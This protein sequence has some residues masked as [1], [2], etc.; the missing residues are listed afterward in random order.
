MSAEYPQATHK[1][2]LNVAGFEIPC[3]VLEDG[4]RVLYQRSLIPALGMSRGASS[5]GKGDRLAIF[6]QG[7][8]LSAFVSDRLREVTSTPF[9]FITDKGSLAYGYEATTLVDIC[10][11]VIEARNA[12]VLQKQQSHIAARCEILMRAFAKV[13]IIALVDEATGYQYVRDRLALEAILDKYLGKELAI[14]EKTFP[15]EFYKH[16]FE[17]RGWHYDPKSSKRPVL[18][19]KL[20]LDIVYRRLAPGLL[21]ELQTRA[22][23]NDKGQ[24]DH[25]LFL[26]L[27]QD[28]GYLRLKEHLS[29]LIVLMKASSSWASFYRLLQRALP[30]YG[31]TLE[32]PFDIDGGIDEDIN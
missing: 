14:W 21:K 25:K 26:L 12:G 31:D 3:Y 17:L 15:D 23:R 27:S 22:P 7:K 6:M 11:A 5:K 20:T 19:G 29:N 24:L 32:L 18:V 4:R 2:I 16:I 13:G 9:T 28:Y 8:A 1:G 10:D 30:K